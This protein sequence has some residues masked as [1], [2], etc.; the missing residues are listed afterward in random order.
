ME[1]TD[2]ERKL[3]KLL[4]KKELE[5]FR[6]EGKTVI[7]YDNAAFPALEERYEEFLE[8]LLKRL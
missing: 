3:L 6:Q 1:L 4:V 7:N 8:K 2:D 5:E